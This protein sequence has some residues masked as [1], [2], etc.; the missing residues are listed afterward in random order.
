MRPAVTAATMA[1]TM[2]AGLL[3][4]TT[5]CLREKRPVLSTKKKMMKT[6]GT[7][8]LVVLMLNQPVVEAMEMMTKKLTVTMTGRIY[9]SQPM[10]G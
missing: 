10:P 9:Q 1:E 3:M 7:T 5:I 8:M 2:E 4:Q 6:T